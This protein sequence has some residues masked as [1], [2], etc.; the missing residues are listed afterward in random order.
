[1]MRWIF[2]LVCMLLG[3]TVARAEPLTVEYT[4]PTATATLAYTS[5]YWCKGAT[6]TSWI[7]A[8]R[9]VSDNGNGGD[10][11]SIQIQIPLTADELPVT[12]RV[13]VTATDTSGNETAGTTP[14]SHTFSAS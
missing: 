1:M 9:V 8:T 5:I 14:A 10:F 13:R 2:I 7:L 3:T 6:C 12:V 4:E 11:K